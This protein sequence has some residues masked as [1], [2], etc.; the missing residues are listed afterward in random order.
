MLTATTNGIAIVA[1]GSVETRP[2]TCKGLEDTTGAIMVVD[3]EGEW[4]RGAGSLV[5]VGVSVMAVGMI[6]LGAEGDSL[7][8]RITGEVLLPV[9]TNGRG[10]VVLGSVGA[11]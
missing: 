8:A 2:V 9:T 1:L 5:V 6:L 4:G 7:V 10:I 11:T 3:L